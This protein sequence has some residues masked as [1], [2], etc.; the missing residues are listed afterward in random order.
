MKNLTLAAI[1]GL[2]ITVGAL[3]QLNSCVQKSHVSSASA[4]VDSL[5][6]LSDSGR[7]AAIINSPAMADTTI[8]SLT[9]NNVP[10]TIQ[11]SKVNATEM[12]RHKAVSDAVPVAMETKKTVPQV[13]IA[14]K[15]PTENKEEKKTPDEVKT[16]NN[17]TPK[18]VETGKFHV[19][20][21]TFVSEEN[22]QLE[23]KKTNKRTLT[24]FKDG[25]YFRVSAG[26]FTSK[27]EANQVLSQ[28]ENEGMPAFII[29]R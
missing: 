11:E 3:I 26:D 9:D 5:A 23:L 22:A 15:M 4:S 7:L 1:I 28:L 2:V 16:E 25:S 21:G 29:R 17:I 20:V 8:I 6:A 27:T 12:T 13:N 24:V 14:P 10:L 18:S 19:I